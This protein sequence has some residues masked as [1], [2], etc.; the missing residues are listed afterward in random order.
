MPPHPSQNTIRLLKKRWKSSGTAL[1]CEKR[2]GGLLSCMEGEGERKHQGQLQG[3]LCKPLLY[4]EVLSGSFVSKTQP[5]FPEDAETVEWACTKNRKRGEK[6]Q[7]KLIKSSDYFLPL[8][9]CIADG[10]RESLRE[11]AG[12]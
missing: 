10:Q 8:L 5:L 6:M 7:G 11:A 4:L 9:S 1:K 2:F 12:C 3:F